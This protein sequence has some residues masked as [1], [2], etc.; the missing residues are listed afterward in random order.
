MI[1]LLIFRERKGGTEGN[2]DVREKHR[3]RHMRPD[4]DQT[5]NLGM[6]PDGDTNPQTPGARD[7]APTQAIW[8]GH[9]S[10]SY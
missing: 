3:L 9:R 8:S 2:F 6:C 5:H 1:Y 7:D 10:L 4:W